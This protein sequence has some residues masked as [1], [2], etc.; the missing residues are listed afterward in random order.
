MYLNAQNQMGLFYK[1][2]CHWAVEVETFN[3]R[4]REA[5]AGRPL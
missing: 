4:T 2:I 5:E 1:M 3:P